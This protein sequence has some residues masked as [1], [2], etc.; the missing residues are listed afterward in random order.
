[1]RI[2][3]R[4]THEAFNRTVA[5]LLAAQIND[6]P[7]SVLGMA[8]GSTTAG[9]HKALVDLFKQ[10]VVSFKEAYLVNKDA[11]LPKGEAHKP[12]AAD[13][14]L[15]H[16]AEM[17]ELIYDHVDLPKDHGFTADCTNPDRRRAMEDHIERIAAL[18]GV[19]VQLV[20]PGETGHIGFNQPGTPFGARYTIA[21]TP[22]SLA[23]YA[24]YHGGFDKLPKA[25]MSL[26]PKS[27]MMS[28]KLIFCAK[29]LNKAEIIAKALKGPVT[30]DL[31]ASFVQLHPNLVVVL[32]REAA[33]KL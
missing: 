30:E 25:G 22:E 2:I 31:P 10:G 33:S 15:S 1:M 20:P 23:F 29:G 9:I 24:D 13:H 5:L 12:M 32:D 18:G 19:D 16:Y 17:K 26:G 3:V 14:L 21:D 8:V 4:D 11:M 27:I 6:K 28:R 7:N